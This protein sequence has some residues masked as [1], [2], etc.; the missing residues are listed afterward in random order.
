MPIRVLLR[1]PKGGK[2]SPNFT[3]MMYSARWRNE[4][5]TTSGRG[6]ERNELD[7]RTNKE[8]RCFFIVTVFV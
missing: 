3:K 8:R 7:L 5:K 1:R 2:I 6:V 4:R